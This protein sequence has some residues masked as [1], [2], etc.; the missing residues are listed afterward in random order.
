MLKALNFEACQTMLTKIIQQRT[1]AGVVPSEEIIGKGL[2]RQCRRAGRSP[3]Q[4]AQTVGDLSEV[5]LGRRVIVD[6]GRGVER[7]LNML[8]ILGQVGREEKSKL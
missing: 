1:W 4:E 7:E 8:G 6:H 3:T 2:S 5:N